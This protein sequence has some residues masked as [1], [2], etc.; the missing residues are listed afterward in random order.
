MYTN[1]FRFTKND[2][3]LAKSWF[4]D[5]EINSLFLPS[6]VIINMFTS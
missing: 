2:I 1:N 3:S 5:L 6:A 4:C